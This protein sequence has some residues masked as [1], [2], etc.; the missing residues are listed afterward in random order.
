M[1]FKRL[2]AAILQAK[3]GSGVLLLAVDVVLLLL[4]THDIWKVQRAKLNYV[5][6][7]FGDG[8]GRRFVP[9]SLLN[10][11]ILLLLPVILV[12]LGNFILF[13][14]AP[15][16]YYRHT[17]TTK[18]KRLLLLAHFATVTACVVHINNLGILEN[19]AGLCGNLGASANCFASQFGALRELRVYLIASIAVWFLGLLV[20]D[21][22]YKGGELA[23]EFDLWRLLGAAGEYQPAYGDEIVYVNS[24][25]MAPSIKAISAATQFYHESYQRSVPTSDRAKQILLE[26]ANRART[27]LS[28]YL[29][30]DDEKRKRLFNIE[31]FPGTSRALEAGIL[32]VGNVSQVILSQYEHPSQIDVAR[33]LCDTHGAVT[34]SPIY[35]EAPSFFQEQWQKQRDAVVGGIRAAMVADPS[36]RIAVILSEV[37]YL[38]GLKIRVGE[39]I[40]ALRQ[41]GRNLV[42]IIDASQAVGNLKR[43]LAEFVEHLRPDD[44]YYF[45]AHKWLLSPNTCG[46]LVSQIRNENQGIHP[47]DA[48]GFELPTS[49]IDPNTVFGLVAALEFLFG[50][51]QLFERLHAVSLVSRDY[52]VSLAE[53]PGNRFEVVR[54]STTDLNVSLFVAVKPKLGSRW[55]HDKVRFWDSIVKRGVDLTVVAEAPPYFATKDSD[56]GA[57]SGNYLLR[58]S[59][60]YFLVGKN[61]RRLAKHLNDLLEDAN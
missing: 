59:F 13:R 23:R 57:E 43:P 56:D 25:S 26:K 20:K 1:K 60:P 51:D 14:Y 27:L 29:L 49:T 6:L 9:D 45:S 54:C 18:T 4:V 31:F 15:A 50:G 10:F 44:L 28:N 46:V 3:Y 22:L 47:Y 24:A 12:L 33:W 36:A 37:H 2:R 21:T 48:F 11:S 30:R 58:I 38:T 17:S 8:F 42:F 53:G 41:A 55:R 32:R 39:I 19:A 40:D 7:A 16:Y 52:F 34:F 5:A 61:V 35:T